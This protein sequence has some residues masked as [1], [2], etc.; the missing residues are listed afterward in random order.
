MEMCIEYAQLFHVSSKR[1]GR[2]HGRLPRPKDCH[3]KLPNC[4][5][6][7]RPAQTSCIAKELLEQRRPIN[8]IGD[9]GQGRAR[10]LDDLIGIDPDI[11]WL[12]A[13]LK[14]HRY[15]FAGMLD[16]LWDQDRPRRPPAAHSGGP[17]RRAHRRQPADLP[18]AAPLR[19][20]PG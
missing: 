12:Y 14:E 20:H 7:L 11:F 18:A 19:R 15:S 13:D 2:R 3:M 9:R 6:C 10:L 16:T 8:L 5:H 1:E 4:N 17:N